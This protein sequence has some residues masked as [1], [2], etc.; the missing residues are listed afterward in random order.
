MS[1]VTTAKVGYNQ[2]VHNLV[3]NSMYTFQATYTLREHPKRAPE[4]ALP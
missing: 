4:L 2:D 3:L 1:V